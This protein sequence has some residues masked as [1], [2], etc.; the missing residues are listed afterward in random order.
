M[1]PRDWLQLGLFIVGLIAITPPLG[2]FLFRVF[3]GERHFFARIL[4]LV[5]H[6][7]YRLGGID[8]EHEM[9]WQE[10]AVALLLFNIVSGALLLALE[11]TQAWLPFN[12]QHLPNVPFPLAFNTAVSFT[13]NTNWQAYPGE[14]TLSYFTQMTGLAVH[15]FV[16][17]AT[18]MAVAVGLA[19]GL[20]HRRATTILAPGEEAK[21]LEKFY[22]GAGKAAGGLGFGLSLP[23]T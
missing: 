7:I 12:P 6:S 1:H 8:P 4:G 2:N 10:Y 15:N 21:V 18:G 3:S 17:A 22:R 16:S 20:V 11:L 14:A 19:R 23:V 9:S 13:T 5:E